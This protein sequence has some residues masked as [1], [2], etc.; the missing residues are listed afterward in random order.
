M[1]DKFIEELEEKK[2]N[3]QEVV[4]L[5][6]VIERLK[7]VNV[8]W[9]VCKCEITSALEDVCNDELWG[10]Y[11]KELDIIKKSSLNYLTHKLYDYADF[12]DIYDCAR[13]EIIE[14]IEV[15]RRGNE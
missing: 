3:N 11:E 12:S 13:S 2:K 5:D 10:Q 1:L 4:V 8:Y 15:L 14:E 7:E 9:D 6:Y